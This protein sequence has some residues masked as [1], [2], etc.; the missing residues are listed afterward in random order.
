LFSIGD[1]ELDA[2]GNADK[3]AFYAVERAAWSDVLGAG[4]ELLSRFVHETEVEADASEAEE[5][6]GAAATAEAA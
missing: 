5:D 1:C 4:L 6:S 3:S 2:V